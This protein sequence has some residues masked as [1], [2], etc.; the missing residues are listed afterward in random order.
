M[1]GTERTLPADEHFNRLP[2]A[3]A[4]SLALLAEECAEV[5]QAIGKIQRHGLW[6]EHPE[7]GIP[8]YNTLQREIG[9]VLAAFRIAEVQ[10]LVDW[11]TVI[12]H[13]DK[14]L[15]KLHG[16]TLLHHAKVVADE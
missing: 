7:S 15:L 10:K 14:K 13:R 1:T 16:T 5:I 9:D 3:Q 6:S 2:P 12:G 4:E 8:N 11:G